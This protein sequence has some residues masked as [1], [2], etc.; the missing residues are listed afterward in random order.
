[1][2]FF[3]YGPLRD[4]ATVLINQFGGQRPAALKRKVNGGTATRACTVVEVDYSP[5]DRDGVIILATDRR[6]LCTDEVNPPPDAEEDKLVTDGEELRIVTAKRYKP[7]TVNIM[8]D[9][10]VRR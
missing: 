5:R 1:M 6:F 9:L 10:Q 3:D 7:A 8:W 2:S 4:V